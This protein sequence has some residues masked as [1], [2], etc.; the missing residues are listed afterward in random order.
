MIDPKQPTAA[1]DRYPFRDHRTCAETAPTAARTYRSASERYASGGAL[2][3]F[4]SIKPKGHRIHLLDG[5]PALSGQSLFQ[6]RVYDEA[7]LPRL[8]VS[9]HNN[10][11]IGKTV[12]KGRWVGFPIFTLT[13]E[14]RRTCPSTCQE[15]RTCYGN[16]MNWARRIKATPRFEDRLWAELAG[17][18]R[19]HPRGFVVR[20]HVLGDFYSV[21][22]VGLWAEALVAFPAL[23]VF[24]YTAR[25]P[26][27]PIGAAVR[28]LVERCFDRFA[29]RFSGSDEDR[30]GSVVVD[31]AAETNH[32][33]CPA[34][35]GKT[36]CCA[37]CVLCW[38]S[39]RTIAFLRH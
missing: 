10:R 15:W 33:I 3:R 12:M 23:N 17:K 4:E 28:V 29:I 19:R 32:L 38:Q 34:Q 31:D 8:L 14:E 26:D 30:G 16:G 24:G 22:Y 5:H 25:L 37:T 2:R 7:E 18:Q 35:L 1:T 9:G 20:P 36:D 13:L 39:D 11:K 27:D 6:A 21:D